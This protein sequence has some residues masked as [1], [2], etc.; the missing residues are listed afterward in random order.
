M[1][2]FTTKFK[3]KIQ[4]LKMRNEIE[5][6]KR[7]EIKKNNHQRVGRNLPGRPINSPRASLSA[8]AADDPG[9]RASFSISAHAPAFLN[10]RAMGLVRQERPC[11]QFCSVTE[12][13][14][15]ARADQNPPG[16]LAPD[17]ISQ[18]GTDIWDYKV[19]VTASHSPMSYQGPP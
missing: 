11:P 3:F 18:L 8:S 12:G 5:K 14:E 10:R 16:I 17:P 13:T 9:L 6:N 7:K 19:T 1:C 2:K 15:L 4:D